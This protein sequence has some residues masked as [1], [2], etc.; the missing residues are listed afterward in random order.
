MGWLTDQIAG[1]PVA[2]AAPSRG[3]A[4]PSHIMPGRARPASVAPQARQTFAVA[5]DDPEDDYHGDGSFQDTVDHPEAYRGRGGAAA[6]AK[7][8][9]CPNCESP[10]YFT[11]TQ[12][13]KGKILNTV[14]GQMATV[15]PHCN[16]CG[17]NGLF[18][19]E[20]EGVSGITGQAVHA[21]RQFETGPASFAIIGRVG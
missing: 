5:E 1:A 19:L 15:A 2:P 11:R 18:D 9:L 21:A 13:S 4:T 20:G 7:E 8:G 17:Y 6:K 14:T 10:N 12:A 16:D 3:S